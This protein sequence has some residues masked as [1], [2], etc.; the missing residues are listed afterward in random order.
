MKAP[1]PFRRRFTTAAGLTAMPHLC[2]REL[3]G[4]GLGRLGPRP[5]VHHAGLLKQLLQLAA[6]LI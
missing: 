5:R 1:A 6:D 3:V 4:A 2:Q